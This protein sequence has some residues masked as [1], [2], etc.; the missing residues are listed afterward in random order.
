MYIRNIVYTVRVIRV[1]FV[2]AG[3][4][5]SNSGFWKFQTE[6]KESQDLLPTNPFILDSI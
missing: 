2:R 6:T 4:F 3:I 1:L 5:F